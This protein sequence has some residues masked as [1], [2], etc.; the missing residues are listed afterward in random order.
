[1]PESNPDLVPH[2]DLTGAWEAF[3]QGAL[4]RIPRDGIKALFFRRGYEAREREVA[5]YLYTRGADTMTEALTVRPQQSLSLEQ[6]QAMRDQAG[7]LLKSNF[8]PTSIKTAEQAVAIAMMAHELGIGM[9]A[10]FSS[11]NVIQGKP[12]ISVQLMLALIYRSG[13]CAKVAV[14][15]ET[16][17]RCTVVMQRKGQNP[18][19]E[20]F[21]VEDAQR[22]N[23]LAKDNWK[24]QPRTMLRWRAV[25]ACARVCFTDVILGLYTADELGG[26]LPMGTEPIIDIDTHRVLDARTGEI[27]LEATASPLDQS[28][29][30]T[31]EQWRRYTQ[32]VDQAAEA[33]IDTTPYLVEQQDLTRVTIRDLGMHLRAELDQVSVP[34]H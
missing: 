5:E 3:R 24:T 27:T 34:S 16:D 4:T 20:T 6:W 12:T 25:A 10:G 33:G 23:L 22:L 15:E 26:D 21:T 9:W 2:Y 13:L 31:D 1:M 8:L 28:G 17:T 14:T 11:I 32:L 29:P 30:A 19:S 18:H 7:I